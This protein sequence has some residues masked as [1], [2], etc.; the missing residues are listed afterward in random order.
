MFADRAFPGRAGTIGRT[1]HRNFRVTV[2]CASSTSIPEPYHAMAEDLGRRIAGAGWELVF[3]GGSTGLMGSLGRAALAAGGPVRSVILDKFLDLGIGL[4]EV[5]E[6]EVV[7]DLR[8]RKAR[9][10][11]LADAC[12][13]LPGG[14]GTFEELSEIIVR[15]QIGV[16]A[17]PIVILNH[18]GFY[19]RLLEFFEEARSRGF[20]Q[21]LDGDDLYR[22]AGTPAE[23][24]EILRK[25]QTEKLDPSGNSGG[26]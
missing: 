7:E 1:M 23:A 22:V 4:T 16:H 12:I 10:E 14:Y 21:G 26:K 24:I 9:L 15:K 25:I 8:P 18:L 6:M 11:A 13:A 3:G 17:K 5:P 20:I 2:Y 19:D